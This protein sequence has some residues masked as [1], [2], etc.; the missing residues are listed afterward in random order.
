MTDEIEGAF[1]HADDK[2]PETGDNE[3]QPWGSLSLSLELLSSNL[4]GSEM[5]LWRVL[6][7]RTKGL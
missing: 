3:Q 6:W 1:R 4:L 5:K 7:T 2:Q